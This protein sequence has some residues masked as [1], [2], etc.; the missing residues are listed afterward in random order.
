MDIEVAHQPSRGSEAGPSSPAGRVIVVTALPGELGT[1][2]PVPRAVMHIEEALERCEDDLAPDG[3]V[4]VRCA[5][6]TR[7]RT[8][9]SQVPISTMRHRPANAL[10]KEG[11]FTIT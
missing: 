3:P 9:L 5:S 10:A 4:K 6:S 8:S 11:T 2:R 1:S 7:S